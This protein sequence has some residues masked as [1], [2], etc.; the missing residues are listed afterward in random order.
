MTITHGKCNHKQQVPSDFWEVLSR[1]GIEGSMKKLHETSY[2]PNCIG[3][4][5]TD[6][7]LSSS[8]KQVSVPAIRTQGDPGDGWS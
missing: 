2:C 4:H 5:R 8:G 7:T 6:K 3:K 1:K